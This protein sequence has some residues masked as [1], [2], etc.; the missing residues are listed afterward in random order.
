MPLVLRLAIAL[1]SLIQINS[2]EDGPTNRILQETGFVILQED[3]SSALLR[4]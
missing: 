4:E 2:A 1:S 3:G